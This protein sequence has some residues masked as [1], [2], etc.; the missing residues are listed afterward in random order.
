MLTSINTRT[1]TV[2][3][4]QKLPD[5][6]FHETIRNNKDYGGYRAG[7][8]QLGFIDCFISVIEV[9]GKLWR[10]E[11]LWPNDDGPFDFD[12]LEDL[13]HPHILGI[14]VVAK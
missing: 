14:E 10:V 6:C 7:Y 8:V 11:Y 1:F 5:S 3:E 9:D 4:F 12:D 13:N 2:D